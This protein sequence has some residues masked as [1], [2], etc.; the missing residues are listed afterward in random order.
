[1]EKSLMT[2]TSAVVP[3]APPALLLKQ[4]RGKKRNRD[5]SN[6]NAEAD[7]PRKRMKMVQLNWSTKWIVKKKIEEWGNDEARIVTYMKSHHDLHLF[8]QQWDQQLI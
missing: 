5:N 3:L 8:A 1:M 2:T 7:H 4:K 6:D